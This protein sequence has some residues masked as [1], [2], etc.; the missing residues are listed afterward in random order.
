MSITK[1]WRAPSARR[2]GFTITRGRLP[3]LSLSPS[4]L[5]IFCVQAP[6]SSR[7]FSSAICTERATPAWVGHLNGYVIAEAGR[8]AGKQVSEPGAN[9]GRRPGNDLQSAPAVHEQPGR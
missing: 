7:G 3:D 2:T 8:K 5:Q 4:K 1:R 9:H 6:R